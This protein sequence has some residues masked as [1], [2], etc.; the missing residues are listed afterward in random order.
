MDE[1][2]QAMKLAAGT[3]GGWSFR[4]DELGNLE[5]QHCIILGRDRKDAEAEC[6]KWL[7]KNPDIKV[8]RV[9]P[10]APEPMN[11]LSLIGGRNVPRFSI[12]VE[13]E[14]VA[15]GLSTTI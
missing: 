11:W 12:M 8:V 13:Y 15:T 5:M 7:S 2:R 10:S 1:W 3:C 9:H 6:G 14:E 4:E